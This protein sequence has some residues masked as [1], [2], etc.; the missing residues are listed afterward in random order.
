MPQFHVL[1]VEDDDQ[2]SNMY[3]KIL[4]RDG[5]R[6]LLVSTAKDAITQLSLFDPDVICLD[7]QLFDGNCLPVLEALR[8]LDP[9]RRPKVLFISAQMNREDFVVHQDVVHGFLQKP[10]SLK[11]LVKTVHD[12]AQAGRERLKVQEVSIEAI[13]PQVVHVMLRGRLTPRL[14]QNT[15]KDMVLNAEV[16]IYDIRQLEL[17]K[18]ASQGAEG[19]PQVLAPNL[20][21]VFLVH[22]PDSQTL[23]Q[24]LARFLPPQMTFYY[25][26]SLEEAVQVALAL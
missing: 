10:F 14:F 15:L 21:H 11:E 4:Q 1:I 6:T 5:F 24:Y 9:A 2:L 22:N 8:Q 7:W 16:L 20:R 3:Q 18:T 25:Y 13:S 17:E 19:F 26:T 23:A 12:L